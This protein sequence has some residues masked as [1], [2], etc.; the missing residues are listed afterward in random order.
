MEIIGRKKEIHQ[1]HKA[2]NSQEAEF[3]V[4]YGR[5][6]I[7]KTYLIREFFSQKPCVFIHATGQQK[8]SLQTQLKNFTESLSQCFTS[9]ISLETPASW[10][11]AFKL[12]DQLIQNDPRPKDQKIVLFL[13]ELPWMHTRKSKLLE[14]LDYSWNHRWSTNPRMILIACGSSASWIIKNIIYNKGGLH[15]RCTCEMRLAPFSL[16]ETALFLKYRNITLNKNHILETYLALGGVPYYLKYL[17]PGLTAS[18]NIQKILFDTQ[19]PLKD[20]FNKLFTSLFTD[21]EHYISLIKMIAESGQGLTRNEITALTPKASIGGRLTERL[22]NLTQARFI[23]PHTSFGKKRDVYFKLI[24]EFCLF[25]LSWVEPFQQFKKM[26]DH[27]L[28]QQS[29]PSYHAWSGY[30]FEAVC[31]KHIEA[32]VKALDI[33]TAEFISSWQCKSDQKIKD[34]RGAQIDLLIDR[35]DDAITL[36]EIKYTEQPFSIDK[37][38][39]E[40]LKNKIKMFTEKTKT[41]KQIFLS[42]ISANG[43]VSNSYSK[44]LVS[45]K[46]VKL[47]DLFD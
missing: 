36:C 11:S 13:D 26:P 28:K 31:E 10:E 8:G 18:E 23:E 2:M 45:G 15:N 22:D 24:D 14:T 9:G 21:A 39:A 37:S 30:A 7:G 35:N 34:S 17:E 42:F 40:N 12:L 47:E 38:Y 16:S 44:E 5:R 3:I 33:K 4:T 19:A 6:R 43:L 32:I 25:Y 41:Q 20:E 27:W 29:K 46:V 1:L